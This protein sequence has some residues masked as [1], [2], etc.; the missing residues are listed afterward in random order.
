MKAPQIPDLTSE[1]QAK[2]DRIFEI[3]ERA[4]IELVPVDENGNS[5]TK[6]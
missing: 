4:G 1:D 6:H 5:E 3:L 2:L